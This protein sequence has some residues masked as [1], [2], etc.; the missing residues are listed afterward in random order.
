MITLLG[1]ILQKKS[2]VNWKTIV[3]TIQNKAWR[4]KSAELQQPEGQKLVIEQIYTRNP[5]KSAGVKSRI[6][7]K[8]YGRELSKFDEKHHSTNPK[9][10][11]N[12]KHNKNIKAHPNKITK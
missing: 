12:C 8:N 11:I 7:V 5:G 3:E 9:S 10:L 2:S 4:Q 1:N 6:Y